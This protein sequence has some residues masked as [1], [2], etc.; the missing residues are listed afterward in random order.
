VNIDQYLKLKTKLLGLYGEKDSKM[1]GGVKE[2]EHKINN[3]C[4]IAT[5]R[6][7]D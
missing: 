3:G 5:Q 6:N 7:T 2:T 1:A 4:Q